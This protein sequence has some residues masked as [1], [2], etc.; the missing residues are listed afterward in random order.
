MLKNHSPV[1][2]WI[3]HGCPVLKR[4]LLGVCPVLKISWIR[5]C[6]TH[7]SSCAEK[8]NVSLIYNSLSLAIKIHRNKNQLHLRSMWSIY[9]PIQASSF[10]IAFTLWMLFM[11]PFVNGRSCKTYELSFCLSLPD[12]LIFQFSQ[13]VYKKEAKEYSKHVKNRL[14]TLSTISSISNWR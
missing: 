4:T 5:H 8:K 6:I 13:W 10:K 7:T 9:Q 12:T 2:F 3:A 11:L 14:T 1:G